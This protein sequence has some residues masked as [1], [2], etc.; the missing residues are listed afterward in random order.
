MKKDIQKIIDEVVLKLK[1]EKSPEEQEK[2]LNEVR[3]KLE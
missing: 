1:K 3:E 2:I